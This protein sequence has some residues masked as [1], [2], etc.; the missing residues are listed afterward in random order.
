MTT[1]MPSGN[2]ADYLWSLLPAVYRQRDAEGDAPGSLRAFIEVLAGQAEVVAAELSGLYEDLFIET[3]QPKIVPYIGDLVAAMPLHPVGTPGASPRALVANTVAYRQR[4]GTVAAL[5]A[6]ARDVTGWPAK[7]V[8]GISVVAT[9]QYLAHLR[10]G[11]GTTVNLRDRSSLERLGGPFATATRTADVRTPPTGMAAPN[12]LAIHVWRLPTF[13]VNESE[14]E[15]VTDPPDGRYQFDVSGADVPLFNPPLPTVGMD[16]VAT[17]RNAAG[18][19]ERLALQDALDTERR[20]PRKQPSGYFGANPVIQVR[21]ADGP[22]LWSGALPIAVANL[23]DWRRRPVAGVVAVDPVLGRLALAEGV[24][25]AQ[26]EVNYTYAGSAIGAGPYDRSGPAAQ[27]LLSRA[28]FIRVVAP[29]PS[30]MGPSA[31][32][33]ASADLPSAVNDW[34][35][36]PPGTVGVIA[37]IDNHAHRF[38]DLAIQIPSGSELFLVALDW[39]TGMAAT[40][41][42]ALAYVSLTGRRPALI[43]ALTV[44]GRPGDGT[45]DDPAPGRFVLDGFVLRGTIEAGRGDRS[46]PGDLGRLELRHVTAVPGHSH[47]R[48]RGRNA[49]PLINID[50]VVTLEQCITGTVEIHGSGPDLEVAGSVIDGGGPTHGAVRA[51]DAAVR[52]DAVTL[53]GDL[54]AERLEASDCL[55]QGSAHVE[56]RQE[57]YVRFSAISGS[58]RTPRRFRCVFDRR[59][60]VGPLP[61][62]PGDLTDRDLPFRSTRFGDPDYAILADDAPEDLLTGSSLGSDIGAHRALLRPQRR[63]NLEAALREHLRAGLEAGVVP[64]T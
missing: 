14:P 29:R 32:P 5:E 9:T 58:A 35:Q 52:L 48:I 34:H 24:R 64:M 45:G 12:K 16:T 19:L 39:P 18:P 47:I 38:P 30:A 55:V 54:F 56:R 41:P 2:L 4:K 61:G 36:Q 7:V 57:G 63:S 33:L 8:E 25:P 10:P 59:P 22:G 53:L 46:R 6:V 43:G 3:C 42:G 62:G 23:Q 26:V 51:N 11:K 17:E 13:T 21:T 28:T 49:G 60:A 50:L 1:T 20:Q 44:T 15:A 31:P 27:D 37:V 40:A